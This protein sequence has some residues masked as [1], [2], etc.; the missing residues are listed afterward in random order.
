MSKAKKQTRGESS[1]ARSKRSIPSAKKT[2]YSDL[3]S[4]KKDL[5]C[6]GFLYVVTLVLFHAIVFDDSAF[7]AGG[8]TASALSYRKAGDSIK[9]TEGIDPL[10]MPYFFSGMPTFGNVA[11]IPHNVSYL[12]TIVINSLDLLFLNGRWTWL[13]VYYFLSGVFMF[14]LMR[15]LKFSRAPALL[16]ALIFMLNPYGIG[17]AGEGHG[18]KLKALSYVP[19][20]FLLTH[21]LFERRDILSFGLLAAGIGT[22]LL[23]NH[24]QI[25]YYAFIVIGLYLIYHIIVDFKLDKMLAVS[26]TALFVGALLIGLCISSYVYLS[27]YEYAQYSIRGG[28][29]TGTPG[30]LSYDY[31]TNWSFHPFEMINYLIPSFFGF[32]STYSTV[33]Q[34]RIQPLPLYWGTMPFNT[35]SIYVGIIPIL[36]SVIALI[37][38]R[39]RMTNFLA[40]LSALVF[41][42]S[43]GKHF[44][45][46]YDLWFN[47]MPFFNKF[48]APV[49]ILHLIAFT[50]SILSAYGLMFLFEARASSKDLNAHTLKKVLLYIIG[51][52]GA[53]LILAFLV[54]SWIF[55]NLATFMFV[56]EG[57][58]YGAQTQQT[59]AAF[60]QIRFDLLWNDFIKFVLIAGASIGA[61]VMFL[62]KKIKSMTLSAA[63]IVI[64][65]IDLVIVDIKFINPAPSGALEE[66]FQP[67]ATISFLKKEPGLFRI[68]PVAQPYGGNT[69]AYH[70]I[71]S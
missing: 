42:I 26:K 17:L 41:L 54:K 67:D 8:D 25:V 47:Y 15:S 22:L 32:S 3:T 59:I 12:E 20:V 23:T 11:Y 56:K 51:S 31:A 28:G 69:F 37:Y 21:W 68:Y 6:I 16:A 60:K 14:L 40:I 39:N 70:G 46:L 57:E 43:F 44:P 65:I 24:M 5:L 2:W 7:Q 34:G 53:V 33:W 55:E 1:P 50:T 38:R 48:R 13:V 4:T 49:M 9:E 36:L 27:V 10:W 62:N 30:G 63:I 18:S 29:T 58:H 66:T 64:L 19:F 45:L 61:I 52:L 71:Q 35:S